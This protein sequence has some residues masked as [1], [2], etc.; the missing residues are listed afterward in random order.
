[1][2]IDIPPISASPPGSSPW[3]QNGMKTGGAPRA[4]YDE[5]GNVVEALKPA[6]NT[7]NLFTVPQQYSVQ[8]VTPFAGAPRTSYLG[9]LLA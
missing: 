2:M 3:R 8:L 4:F 6:F 9:W 5:A 1:M 7:L